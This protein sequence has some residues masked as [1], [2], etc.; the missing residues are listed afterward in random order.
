MLFYGNISF[1]L[2]WC[3]YIK[4]HITEFVLCVG[5]FVFYFATHSVCCHLYCEILLKFNLSFSWKCKWI[6]EWINRMC[7]CLCRRCT[8]SEGHIGVNTVLTSCG[9]SSPRASVVQVTLHQTR[10]T[11]MTQIHQNYAKSFL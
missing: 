4:L 11:Q 9:V 2:Q 8:P 10:P 6:D 1:F 5:V 7:F 3:V